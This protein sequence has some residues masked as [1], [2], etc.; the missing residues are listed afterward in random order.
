MRKYLFVIAALCLM[1]AGA[2]GQT[3]KSVLDKCAATVTSKDGASASFT[4]NSAQYGNTQGTIAIKGRMFHT[5]TSTASMWF[6]GKTLWTYME[7]NDEVN[8]STPTEQQLQTLNPYNFINLY[9]KG[10]NTSMTTSASAYIVHLTATSGQKI[11]EA[12]VTVDKTTYAPQEIKILQG[13]KWTT[14]TVSNL[15]AEKLSDAAFQFDKSKY[16]DVEVIDLR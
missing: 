7:K 15:K 2:K 3:A 12:F 8:I 11:Q 4:M 9:K 14:F 5:A 1:G 10:F 13:N 16:P 6:D